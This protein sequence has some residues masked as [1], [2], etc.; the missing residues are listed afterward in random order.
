[1]EMWETMWEESKFAEIFPGLKWYFTTWKKSYFDNS[2]NLWSKN[3]I[4]R[5]FDININTNNSSH[6]YAWKIIPWII[7]IPL[8]DDCL[9]DI[10]SL[11]FSWKRKPIFKLD[12]NNCLYIESNE[13]QYISFNFYKNQQKPIIQPILEDS[14]KIIFSKL[15][16][17]TTILLDWLK[18][19]NSLISAEKIKQYIIYTKKYSTKVQG[20]LR[21]K[22]NSKNYI[23]NIDKSEIMECFTA[24]VLFVALCRE[25]W[26]KSRLIT[27]HMIQN[28]TK[29][30][31]WLLSNNNWHAWSEVW[32]EKNNIW[33]RFDATPT[34]KEDW[35]DSNQNSDNSNNNS[36]D[37]SNSEE[38]ENQSD[39]S[40][41]ESNSQANN[42]ST[43]QWEQ[44]KSPS[45]M[46]DELIDKAK[47]EDLVKQSE[48][49]KETLEKLE[50]SED[51]NEIKEIMENS[52]LEDFAKEMIDNIWN[53]EILKQ[54]EKEISQLENEKDVDNA[55][56]DSLLNEEFKRKLSEYWNQIKKQIQEEKKKNQSEMNRMWFNQEEIKLYK[57]Y[58]KLEQDLEPEVKKQI[59]A[60]EKILP[61]LYHEI[62]NEND[63]YKSWPRIWN[64]AK[65]IEYELTWDNKVFRRNHEVKNT[66]E[67]NMF[68]TIIIDRSWSMWNFNENNSALRESV[69]A[70][71]IRAK[72]LE[73]FKVNFSIVLFDTELEE[74]MNF[75]EKFS[76]KKKN[77]IPSR[78]M[79]AVMKNWWTDIW[80]PLTYTLENMKKYSRKNWKKSFW[81][82][83]FLW[84]GEP[85]DWL[86]WNW[87]KTLIQEIKKSWFWLT[88]YYINWSNQSSSWLQDYFGSID[89]W[90]TII[91]QN[92]E[93]LTWKLISS[94]NE[95]LRN[96]IKKYSKNT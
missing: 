32:D 18:W 23:A 90:Q 7:A 65:L 12:Q 83:S 6:T 43:K 1:M 28:I 74:I 78:L 55:I 14:E 60:L 57:L 77:N 89:S 94:Y 87:L 70:A 63:Y 11:H 76:D 16:K 61:P 9:P 96:I 88:A 25:I 24:N 38:S 26:L 42:N 3:K 4:L 22:S 17:E 15:S 34:K 49:I 21:D 53:E 37:N 30:W 68:E 2:T 40:S 13:K 81:N 46:L 47:E 44:Q 58:K 69:K 59:R 80:K 91:V 27:W 86:T 39:N 48:K 29:E 85:S 35:E 36:N 79:R 75:W 72:V 56:N 95:N 19:D 33:V 31:K 62:N 50:A 20:T 84:D 10:E 71:I 82:I 92:I 5:N 52:W 67:I 45:E 41:Q 66:N 93:E 8:K 54:E 73:H 51:K 64:T